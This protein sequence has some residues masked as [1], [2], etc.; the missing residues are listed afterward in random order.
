MPK[1]YERRARIAPHLRAFPSRNDKRLTERPLEQLG[2][3]VSSFFMVLNGTPGS[4]KTVLMMN[5]VAVPGQ[6]Y[7]QV[8]RKVFLVGPSGHTRPVSALDW[9]PR[10]QVFDELTVETLDAVRASAAE[11]DGPCLLM[12]DDVGTDLKNGGAKLVRAL[13]K[14]VLN[15]RHIGKGLSIMVALQV[16]TDMP[17]SLRKN[18]TCAI[19][20]GR[21]MPKE[22]TRLYEE[23][24][25]GTVEKEVFEAILESINRTRY[26]W[27]NIRPGKERDDMFWHNFARLEFVDG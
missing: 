10:E 12:M 2:L 15:R 20:C 7:H 3:P 19:Q 23:L 26:Q 14:T 4:G 17:L 22:V 8:F 13:G 27:L 21:P 11:A 16:W 25:A 24:V 9:L 5:M 18:V 1:V 6:L